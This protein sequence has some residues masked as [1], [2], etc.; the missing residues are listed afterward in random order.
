MRQNEVFPSYRNDVKEMNRLYTYLKS[1][2]NDNYVEELCTMR[3]YVGEDQRNLIKEMQLGYCDD[4]DMDILA[5][6][7]EDFGLIT[8]KGNFLLQNRFLVPITTV[9]NDLVSLVGY[10]SDT[11]KYITI[12][13]NFMSKEC[14]LFRFYNAYKL[15]WEKYDGLV[16]LVEGIFDCLSL[17]SIGLPAMATMGATVSKIKGELLKLFKKVIAIPDD[18]ATGRKALNR[19]SKYG[20]QVPD[21]TTFLKF[22]GGY[23]TFNGQQLHCKDIDNFVSWYEADDVREIL[24]SY[25]DVKE[26][27]TEL[28]IA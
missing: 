19:Y 25:R 17:E 1:T 8:K 27:I 22:K 28:K 21:N 20:W 13:S 7:P 23:Q 15:S 12:S 16:F 18:D 6:F 26:E 4:P 10:Y 3:G 11:R 14:L 2:F 5:T 24:L 9:N